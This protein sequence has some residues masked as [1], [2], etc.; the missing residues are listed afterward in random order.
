MDRIADAAAAGT[1][2]TAASVQWGVINDIAGTVAQVVACCVGLVTIWYYVSKGLRE[3]RR[4]R[5]SRRD[6]D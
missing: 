5:E 1:I 2:A 4:D 3:R 6:R